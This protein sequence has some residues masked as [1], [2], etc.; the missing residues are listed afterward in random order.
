MAFSFRYAFKIAQFASGFPLK[1]SAPHSHSHSVNVALFTEEKLSLTLQSFHSTHP[2]RYCQKQSL[3]DCQTSSLG[4][5]SNRART[6]SRHYLIPTP[7]KSLVW[8]EI[9]MRFS[10]YRPRHHQ[11]ISMGH[12]GQP[13]QSAN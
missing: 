11:Q 9:G 8:S 12:M 2:M 3:D 6:I 5:E 10:G 4:E 13:S 1:F 7:R